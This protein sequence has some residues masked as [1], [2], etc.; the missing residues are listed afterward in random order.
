LYQFFVHEA[1]KNAK[2]KTMAF[3]LVSQA[4]L[5]GALAA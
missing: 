3:R 5:A 4:I 2:A 1:K